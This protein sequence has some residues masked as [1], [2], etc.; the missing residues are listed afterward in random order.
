MSTDHTFSE[1]KFLNP[2]RS[3]DELLHLGS[4]SSSSCTSNDAQGTREPIKI[5][6][7]F[8]ETS[9]AEHITTKKRRTGSEKPLSITEH[10]H[11]SPNIQAEAFDEGARSEIWDIELEKSLPSDDKTLSSQDREMQSIILNTQIKKFTDIDPCPDI[12]SLETQPSSRGRSLPMDASSIRGQSNK[13]QPDNPSSPTPTHSASQV[14]SFSQHDLDFVESAIHQRQTDEAESK[15]LRISHTLSFRT[16]PVKSTNEV[17]KFPATSF[18]FDPFEM[19]DNDAQ[20]QLSMSIL[21]RKDTNDGRISNEACQWNMNVPEYAEQDS[22]D[23]LTAANFN[24]YTLDDVEHCCWQD[25]SDPELKP[26]PEHHQPEMC[27]TTTQNGLDIYEIYFGDYDAPKTL[28][29]GEQ[30]SHGSVLAEEWSHILVDDDYGS[31]DALT[32]QSMDWSGLDHKVESIPES[33][34]YI[35]DVRGS[36]TTTSAFIQG[37]SVLFGIE[38]PIVHDEGGVSL[39]LKRVEHEVAAQLLK[40]HWLPQKL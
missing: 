37:R 36:D 11:K 30:E 28:S 5:S 7:F 26:P 15:R 3:Q 29:D 8:I 39:G 10:A 33:T 22:R 40:D 38:E 4:S 16:R 1:T 13:L 27:E 9:R 35:Q 12:N 6:K 19:G 21:N 34:R 24:D 14:D 18:A 23:L 32:S 31:T 20:T 17:F 2:G 25:E